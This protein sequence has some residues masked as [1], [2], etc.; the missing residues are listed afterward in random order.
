MQ[1]GKEGGAYFDF[2]L[3]GF[4]WGQVRPLGKGGQG[5]VLLAH[6]SETNGLVAI[7][8]LERGVVR[9]RET[10]GKK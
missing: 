9:V 1:A 2:Y 10:A 7:K 5:F 3:I 4:G 6:D 8:V